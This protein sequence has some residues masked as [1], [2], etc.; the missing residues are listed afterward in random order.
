MKRWIYLASLVLGGAIG[1]ALVHRGDPPTSRSDAMER[2]SDANGNLT[3]A[4]EGVGAKISR[5]ISSESPATSGSM[6]INKA[7]DVLFSERK[8]PMR[9]RAFLKSR[10]QMMTTEQ[11]TQTVLAGEVQSP[12]EIDEVA[13]RLARENPEGTFDHLEAGEIRVYGVEN[14][15]IFVDA[16]LQTWSDADAMAV[17]QR[18]KKMKRGGSQQDFSL[19]FSTYWTK[20]DPSAAARNFDDLIYLRNMQVRAD[21]AFTENTY[22]EEIVSSWKRKDENAMRDYIAGLPAGSKKGSFE[23]AVGKLESPK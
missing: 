19:R 7:L 13:R 14:S 6:P 4:P 21:M 1:T 10:I 15:Y 9:T 3:R 18:L 22:A 2:A 12:A 20:I 16:L 17:M 11:L 23:K 5:L 8:S